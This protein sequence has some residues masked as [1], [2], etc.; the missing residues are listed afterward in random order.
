MGR[1][2][3]KI[4]LSIILFSLILTIVADAFV[5]MAYRH[6]LSG[7]LRSFIQS[8]ISQMSENME[9]TVL[10]SEEGIYNKIQQS[11]LIQ[12]GRLAVSPDTPAEN[13]RRLRLLSALLSNTGLK[14]FDSYLLSEDGTEV[15]WSR[16]ARNIEDFRESEAGKYLS[17]N[18]DALQQ[19]RG[20]VL[21][22]RFDDDDGRI[23]IVKTVI[24]P[25]TIR[26]IGTLCLIVDEN[27]FT[28]FGENMNAALTILNSSDQVLFQ[29][30]GTEDRDGVL[31]EE[32]S[33]LYKKGWTLTAAVPNGELFEPLR[34]LIVFLLLLETAFGMACVY[35][36]KKVSISATVNLRSLAARMKDIREGRQAEPIRATVQD[37][38]SE[39][40]EAFNDMNSRLKESIARMTDSQIQKEKAEYNALVAQ[41]NP[42]FIYNSLEAVRAMA[43][44]HHEPEI[45]AAISELSGLMRI[46][47]SV[48]QEKI[49]L[50]MELSYVTQYLKLQQLITGDQFSWDI[51]CDDELTDILVPKLILQPVIE[52]CFVHGF[53]KMPEDAMIII[54]CYQKQNR[55]IVE[56]SDNGQGMDEVALRQFL[57]SENGVETEEDGESSRRHIGLLSIRERIRHLYGTDGDMDI[58][59]RAEQG[60]TVQFRFPIRQQ[61]VQESV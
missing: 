8:A 36:A 59:A 3:K 31:L 45:A 48:K 46:T 25:N 24:N 9:R 44:L 50:G 33:H 6:D 42:H 1:I 37:E 55:L 10:Q 18:M 43:S 57:S 61:K 15:F 29:N 32:T 14:I 28:Q 40:V 38:T 52:N 34:R 54:V 35:I 4:Y 58:R 30:G 7:N 19:N 39:L 11:D 56:I 16:H 51:D 27:S 20:T 53:E 12:N 23:C 22:M 2:Q 5:L 26:R 41:M 60:T 49:A 17:D 13:E 47:L 21:W